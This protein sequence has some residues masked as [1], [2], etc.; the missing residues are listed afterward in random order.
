MEHY[1][2]KVKYLLFYIIKPRHVEVE[3]ADDSNLAKYS[4]FL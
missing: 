2:H 4:N 3:W 1:L